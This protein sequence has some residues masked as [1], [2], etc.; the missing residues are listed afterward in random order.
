MTEQQQE[1]ILYRGNL[2]NDSVERNVA[3]SA[4][5]Q[6]SGIYEEKSTYKNSRAVR[7]RLSDLDILCAGNER[8]RLVNKQLIAK[9]KNQR[10]IVVAHKRLSSLRRRPDTIRQ[11]AEELTV[12]VVE[13]QRYQ[14]KAI[15]CRSGPW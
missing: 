3:V 6:A 7:L 1:A 15:V 13:L 10:T 5:K 4:E 14:S 11:K 2:G 12:R 9:C 8:F